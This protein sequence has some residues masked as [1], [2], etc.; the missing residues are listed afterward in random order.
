MDYDS[1]YDNTQTCSDLFRDY[2][3]DLARYLVVDKNVRGQRVVEVGCG[4]GGFLR[5]LAEFEPQNR[6][7][8]FDPT[9]LG[10]PEELAGRLRFENRYYDQDCTDIRA[11]VVVSRHVIEHV[12]DPVGLLRTIHFTLGDSPHAQVFFETPCLEWILRHQVVWDFCYEH[13][14][15]FTADSL[16]TAFEIAGFDVQGCRHLFGGQYLWIEA[17][18]AHHPV[19]KSAS[20]LDSLVSLAV[21]FQAAERELIDKWRQLVDGFARLGKVAL[22]GAAGK[23]TT[24][25]NLVDPDCESLAV[26][27]DINPRKQGRYLPGTGHRIIAP[28]QLPEFGVKTALVLNPNY[29]SEIKSLL[30]SEAIEVDVIDLMQR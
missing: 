17:I 2:V 13:C 6:L 8:G 12:P 14:S 22:W 23:G 16:Q 25:A 27:V 24:F 15:Y 11:D 7:F 19:T 1:H 4:K 20:D 18:L 10:P 29:C 5:Q 21:A 28:R 30:K 9:Y 26:V 3:S